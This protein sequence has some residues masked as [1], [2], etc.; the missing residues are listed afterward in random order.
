MHFL[1]QSAAEI[2]RFKQVPEVKDRG[3]IRHRLAT[4]VERYETTHRQRVVKRLFCARVLQVEPLLQEVNAQH[5]LEWLG[6]APTARF[7]VKRLDQRAHVS[8]R[9]NAIHLGKKCRAAV[10]F[11]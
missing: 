6:R 1:E 4:E 2:V 8:P 9:H 11:A 10:G 7:R 5:L 3:L